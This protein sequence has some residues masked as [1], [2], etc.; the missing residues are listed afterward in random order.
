MI[1]YGV[2]SFAT[3]KGIRRYFAYQP[4]DV[5]TKDD[6]VYIAGVTS[7]EG[8]PPTH[9]RKKPITEPDWKAPLPYD[10]PG[11]FI[12]SYTYVG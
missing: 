12:T 2:F 4:Y 11:E 5:V 7:A 3:Y 10:L 6:I 9:N 1:G 8:P